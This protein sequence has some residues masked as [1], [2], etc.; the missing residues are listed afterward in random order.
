MEGGKELEQRELV[1]AE[2]ASRLRPQWRGPVF[3]G[4]IVLL[5]LGNLPVLK[6]GA[7][8][9]V[10]GD[11]QLRTPRGLQRYKYMTGYHTM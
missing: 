4:N 5:G 6:L 7:A 10:K 2:D 9:H 3:S 11:K 1:L 8:Q